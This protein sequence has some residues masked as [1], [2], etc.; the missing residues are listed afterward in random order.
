MDI[1]KNPVI[2]GFIIFLCVYLYISWRNKQNENETDKKII[3][4]LPI[5]L[6]AGITAFI[7]MCI[8]N[9][10]KNQIN[11]MPS[12]L[13]GEAISFGK[14]DNINLIENV[15]SSVSDMSLVL[16]MTNTIKVPTGKLPHITI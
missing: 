11:F 2:I 3:N 6:L 1:I 10:M 15:I 7:L 16:P 4:D 8:Y 12:Q 9:G 14:N 13:G 5:P